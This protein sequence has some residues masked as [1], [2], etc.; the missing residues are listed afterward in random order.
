MRKIVIGCLLAAVS[1]A[2][3]SCNNEDNYADQKNR[4]RDAIDNFIGRDVTIVFDGDTLCRVGRINVITEQTFEAQGN[5]TNVDKNEYVLFGGTGVYMQIVRR[6][7]GSPLATDSSKQVICQFLEY[8]IMGDSLQLTSES[9]YWGTNPDVMDVT[10][11]SGTLL[12]T[13]NTATYRP[14]A[15]SSVYGTTVPNGW[16]VPLRYVGLGRKTKEDQDIAKVRMIIPHSQG[17]QTATNAV[18]PFFY[19][20][21]MQEVK[22]Q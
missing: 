17:H 11:S 16:L 18:C 12:G 8:N 6:G 1:F 3:V 15:M 20:I 19:E 13:F 2:I 4:E 22:R 9:Y 5:V 10:N 14:G 7:I 21:K